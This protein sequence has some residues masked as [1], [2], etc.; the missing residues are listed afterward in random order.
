MIKK[1]IAMVGGFSESNYFRN[2]LQE[3]LGDLVILCKP[4]EVT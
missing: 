3:R 4:D 1:T 2:E